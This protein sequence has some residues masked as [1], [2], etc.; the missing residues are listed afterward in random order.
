MAE[1]LFLLP[2]TFLIKGYPQGNYTGYKGNYT[3]EEFFSKEKAP[4]RALE[5]EGGT[6]K[7]LVIFVVQTR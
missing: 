7:V 5:M 3:K 4:V 1:W 2:Y 6:I